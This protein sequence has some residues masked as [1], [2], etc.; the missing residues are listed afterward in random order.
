MI[1]FVLRYCVTLQQLCQISAWYS[2]YNWF[3]SPNWI[4]N[5]TYN[6]SRCNFN[7]SEEQIEPCSM[8]TEQQIF[9]RRHSFCPC[10]LYWRKCMEPFIRFGKCQLWNKTGPVIFEW[11]GTFG[12]AELIGD[13]EG[14]GHS[15]Q[16][17][18]I[19]NGDTHKTANGRSDS[20]FI[21]AIN[22]SNSPHNF[23]KDWCLIRKFCLSHESA[24]PVR[25]RQLRII[26][27]TTVQKRWY[28]SIL[29]IRRVIS[30][31]SRCQSIL[32][33]RVS[34]C[35]HQTALAHTAWKPSAS[36]LQMESF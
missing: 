19:E 28:I 6:R 29:W 24:L 18:S 22:P 23:V 36:N 33:K 5:T 2:D 25:A 34:V 1:V 16:L 11:T 21:G 26:A 8:R 7:R 3:K 15:A 9:L 30:T 14:R 12:K 4:K 10:A 27:E 20:D 31:A 17:P 13:G 35:K 32:D